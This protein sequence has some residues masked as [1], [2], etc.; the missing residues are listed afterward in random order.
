MRTLRAWRFGENG[1]S[2]QWGV[3]GWHDMTGL[4]TYLNYGAN[5]WSQFF[6]KSGATLTTKVQGGWKFTLVTCVASS[7]RFGCG[8]FNTSG[9]ELESAFAQ[10]RSSSYTTCTCTAFL[11]GDVGSKWKFCEYNDNTDAVKLTQ[12]NTEYIIVEYLGA[13]V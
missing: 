1:S 7:T 13:T 12:L 10:S 3:T 6:S 4:F 9:S 5:N 2:H 8:I 11:S